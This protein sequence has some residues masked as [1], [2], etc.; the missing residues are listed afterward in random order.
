MKQ[1][2]N[3]VCWEFYF[4][5]HK[6]ESFRKRTP[7]L[8]K[9]HPHLGLWTS[10]RYI[11]LI[12]GWCGRP[13]V[14]LSSATPGQ[15]LFQLKPFGSFLLGLTSF[16]HYSLFETPMTQNIHC[17]ILGS[18]PRC[19]TFFG[20]LGRKHGSSFHNLS[21]LTSF[22]NN[23]LNPHRSTPRIHK[24]ILLLSKT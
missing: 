7:Q 11:C 20:D 24:E 21:F 18:V 8:G 4:N 9:C 12:D 16:S 14:P 6:P 2:R 10:L 19:I 5:W 23:L 13:Q 3:Q 17:N 15:R 1:H 22:K